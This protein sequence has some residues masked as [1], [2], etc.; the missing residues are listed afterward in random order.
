MATGDIDIRLLRAFAGVAAAGSFMAAARLAGCS[1]GAVSARVRAL[2]AR[3]GARLFERS[4]P[5]ARLTAA[6][7]RLLP[8][9]QALL[10][11]HD[12]LLAG[13]APDQ[14]NG[15]AGCPR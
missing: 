14:A 7:R 3:L 11:R 4:R 6:G 8:G 2:E 15:A 5:H 10:A 13:R 12:R 1:Q 9:A